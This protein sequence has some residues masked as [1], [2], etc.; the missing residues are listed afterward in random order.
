MSAHGR[1]SRKYT[2]QPICQPIVTYTSPPNDQQQTANRNV[3]ITTTESQ[4]QALYSTTS[5]LPPSPGPRKKA[6]SSKQPPHKP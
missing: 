3:H 2:C 6:E 5:G 4:L 1:C